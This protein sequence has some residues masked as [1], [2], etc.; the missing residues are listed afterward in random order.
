M[1]ALNIGRSEYFRLQADGS[2]MVS[3]FLRRSWDTSVR[4]PGDHAPASPRPEAI[5]SVSPELRTGAVTRFIGRER[6]IADVTRLA[7][8]SRM[9]TILGAP[10]AGKTRLAL[11]IAGQVATSFSG[12]TAVISLADLDHESLVLP[13]IGRAFDIYDVS[14]LELERKLFIARKRIE[15]ELSGDQAVY[16]PSLSCRTIVYKGMLTT[17]QLA[18][19]F[20]DLVDERMET[21]LALVH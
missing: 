5:L 19:F 21:A 20:C 6:E 3:D 8:M 13:A 14:P 12:G 4:A 18:E 7:S 15:H 16:F 2:T 9:V 1:A 11:E 17:P 10:G